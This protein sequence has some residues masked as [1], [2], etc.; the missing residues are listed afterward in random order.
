MRLAA[1]LLFFTTM[2]RAAPFDTLVDDFFAQ[3]Y[4]NFSPTAGTQAGF[5][6]YDSQLENYSRKNLVEAQSAALKKYEA[7]FQKIDPATL[8][9]YARGDREMLIGYIHATLHSLENVR[10][11]EKNPDIYSS[12]ITQSAFYIMSRQFAPPADRLRSLIAREKLM[13]QVFTEA[14][15]N[16]KNPPKVY[17]DVAIEQMPGNISFF[18]HDVPQAFNKVSDKK[19]LAEFQ[20]SNAAV[21]QALKGYEAWMKA[22]LLPRAHGDFRLGVENFRK[23]LLY[24]EM[25]DTPLERLLAIG[26]EDL[27]RN[28]QKFREVA[29]AIDPKKT[30][31]QILDEAEKDH[32]PAAKLL[33]AFRDVLG[34]LRAFIEEHHIVTIPSQV[35]PIIEETPPFERALTTA[36]M[37]TPGAYE[38]VA[39][40]A[41]FNVT[42][43]EPNWT[44]AQVEEHMESFNRGVITST[45]IHE[46]FPGHYVQFL[47]LQHLQSKTRKLLFANSNVE[48]WAHYCEQ[49]M[50]DEGYAKGDAKLR[51]GQ[52]Q[53]ALL[54]DARYI[55]GIEMHTGKMSMEQ[56]VDF[57]VKEGMQVRGLGERETKRGTADPTYLYYTLGKLQIMKLR[58]D[59]HQPIL[60]FHDEFLKQGGAPIK[61]VRE[62]MLGNQSPVL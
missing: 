62:A 49:M 44:P 23:K 6:Q 38:K 52:L 22:D 20:Q 32:P 50:L 54:R 57:F 29:A 26:Y 9:A 60:R 11:W 48:G 39:K 2:L 55:V 15:A 27:R 61:I 13:P 3:A 33:Q 56:A 59:Y 18:E 31:R 17:V 7:E 25:V 47:V 4:F 35:M 46:A 19:L 43:P 45:A 40:E 16:L 53:D 42:L 1:A 30:P 36:S 51:L 37:D 21:I 14:H 34:G 58:K 28:Q 12:G 5:H 8:E 41:Y 10:F 24:E